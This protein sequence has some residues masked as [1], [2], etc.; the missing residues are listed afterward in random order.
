MAGIVLVAEF[1]PVRYTNGIRGKW[2]RFGSVS[3]GF[4]GNALGAYGRL[5]RSLI[6]WSI[7]LGFLIIHVFAVGCFFYVGTGLPLLGF[8]PACAAEFMCMALVIYWLP[9]CWSLQAKSRL[10]R[11]LAGD[12]GGSETILK[13]T[14]LDRTAIRANSIPGIVSTA[15][16][17][18]P[19]LTVEGSWDVRMSG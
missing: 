2:V 17:E 18:I 16:G 9:P 13:Q 11:E 3:V 15:L 19:G 7:F 6:F 4:V 12:F 5:R 8:G 10:V 14:A 1:V